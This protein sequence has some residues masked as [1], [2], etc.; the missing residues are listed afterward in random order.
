MH[1]LD[2]MLPS[3][4]QFHLLGYWVAFLAAL[5]ET[6]LVVGLLL[7]GS[8]LLLLLGAFAAAGHLEFTGILWFAVAGAILGDNLNFWLGRHYGH[9]WATK[10]IWFIK[11]EHFEQAHNFFDAHGARSVFLGRFIPSIKEIIPFVAG[12]VGMQRRTFLLWNILGSVGWGLEWV[13]GGYLF[14]QSLSLAQTWMSRAGMAFF[15]LALIWLSLWLLERLVLRHGPQLWNVVVS[16]SHSV[17]DAVRDNPHSQELAQRHPKI[18]RF[19]AERTD[20]SHFHGL[21]LTLLII[22]FGYVL[23]LFAGIVEDLITAD[24]I[25]AVDHAVAQLVAVF[26]VPEMIRPAVW[27]T[28]LGTKWVVLPLIVLTCLT[29][30]L[31]RRQWLILPLLLSSAGA[32]VFSALG[33]IAFHRSRPVEAVLL[34]QSYSFPSGHATIAVAFYGFLGYLLIRWSN[35]W[36][37]RVKLFFLTLILIFLIGLSRIL[38]GVHYLSDVWAGYLIGTL[39]FIIGISFSEWLTANGHIKWRLQSHPRNRWAAPVSSLVAL[40]WYLIFTIQWHPVPYIPAPVQPIVIQSPLNTYLNVRQAAYTETLLGKPAQP[41]GFAIIADD[42]NNMV[43][44]LEKNGWQQPDTP[45]IDAFLQLMNKGMAYTSAPLAPAFWQQHINDFSFEKPATYRDDKVIAT[46]RIWKTAYRTIDAGQVFVGI[47]RE[48]DDISWGLLH[49]TVP[50]IDAAT[51]QL[52]VSLQ[53]G[54]QVDKFC[55]LPLVKPMTGNY[56][57]TGT[58]F[59]RGYLQIIDLTSRLCRHV[60]PQG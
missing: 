35:R 33:K 45:S 29:L 19:L 53:Q 56:L 24:P 46:L 25:I 37:T 51:D 57:I 28:S 41:L 6:T 55:S 17:A 21:P 12:T 44:A 60:H 54:G 10:G 40:C 59:T 27:I 15:V 2:N 8:S 3:I 13:G 23:A 43:A 47:A 16:L 50:D 7:P 48:Y 34:E 42:A 26:R 9:H 4:E 20:R 52:L 22:A 49:H 11:P 5:L 31:L 14:G 39:W 30:W 38:L 18:I 32:S 36:K 58:F 1:M